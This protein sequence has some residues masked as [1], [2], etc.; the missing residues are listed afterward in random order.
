MR[1][2]VDCWCKPVG[3]YFLRCLV[4]VGGNF[5]FRGGWCRIVVIS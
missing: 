2:L 5:C 3:A 1:S 4:L